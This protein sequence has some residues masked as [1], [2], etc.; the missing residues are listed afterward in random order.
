MKYTQNKLQSK[1]MRNCSA[2]HNIVH[3]VTLLNLFLSVRDL[4]NTV[5]LSKEELY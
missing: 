2:S 1:G 3:I 4:L 5:G